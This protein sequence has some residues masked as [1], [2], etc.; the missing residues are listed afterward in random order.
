MI[1]GIRKKGK[2]RRGGQEKKKEGER[3]GLKEKS[4]K[5]EEERE[6]R[7]EKIRGKGR[8][9]GKRGNGGVREEGKNE[10]GATRWE[11]KLRC[12]G[13]VKEEVKKEERRREENVK[14]KKRRGGGTEGGPRFLGTLA[15][16]ASGWPQRGPLLPAS[17]SAQCYPSI[18]R[19][20]SSAT[21]K[22]SHYF[23]LA[24]SK[25]FY[26]SVP[27]FYSLSCFLSTPLLLF[28]PASFFFLAV[29]SL[30]PSV[31]DSGVFLPFFT[32]S[33][34]AM[35]MAKEKPEEES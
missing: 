1:N 20:K 14:N 34:S 6:R 21:R 11:R 18:P 19:P 9:R 24:E 8:G 29:S 3:K 31:P 16:L 15:A 2:E 25:N 27:F 5:R 35:K 10:E 32:F 4:G 7:R 33:C 23:P 30:S 28:V 22:S 12:E 17:P 13:M 26:G